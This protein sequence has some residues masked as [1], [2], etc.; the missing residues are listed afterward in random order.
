M[1]R[2]Q[3]FEDDRPSSGGGSPIGGG[4]SGATGAA[5][6]PPEAASGGAA[7]RRHLRGSGLFLAGRLLA[8]LLN[9][10]AQVLTVRYLSKEDFGAFAYALGVIAVASNVNLLGLNRTVGRSVPIYHE[11]RDY[12]SMFGTIVLAAACIVGMGLA[13]CV[14]TFGLEGFLAERLVKDRR[15]VDLLLVLIALTPLE[16]LDTLLEGV[17]AALASPR[18]IFLRR[19]VLAPSFKLASIALV[20]ALHGSVILLAVFSLLGGLFG[21]LVYVLVLRRVLREQGLLTHLRWGRLRL[22]L[23]ELLGSGIP[24]MTTDI[25]QVL[26]TTMAIFILGYF[27]GSRD[28]ADFRAVVPVAGLTLLV[29]QSHKV[30]FMPTASRLYAQGDRGGL[31]DLYWQSAIWITILTFPIFAACFF[32]ADP[33]TELLFGSRYAAS[34]GSEASSILAI[35]ALGSFLNAAAGLNTYVLQVYGNVG[36]IAAINAIAAAAGLVLNLSLIPGFG[37]WGAAVATTASVVLQNGLNH[38]GLRLRTEIDLFRW[39]AWKV[40][41]TVLAAG[42]VLG[43]ASLLKPPVAV[44]VSLV[45]LASLVF[46]RTSRRSLRLEETFPELGRV[47][48]V[49]EIL[50][51]KRP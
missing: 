35:L 15:A 44:M 40:Y 6:P 13:L 5:S 30:L 26:R 11:R 32:L 50:S 12:R 31:R 3:P 7:A 1:E 39:Q 23:R 38:L 25:V 14:L 47:P 16:A 43:L 28:I 22:P 10:F 34:G 46:L 2:V 9:F 17:T 21:V 8:M 4:G 42:L 20:L 24:L 29:L 19:H 36:F 33:V 27:R 37:A 41:L 18:A 48:L 51:L 49:R 45:A